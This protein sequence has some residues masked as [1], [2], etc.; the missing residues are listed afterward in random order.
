MEPKDYL[1]QNKAVWNS[2]VENH[3]QSDFYNVPSFLE[4]T[5]TLN[6][7]EM[8][9][10]ED[11]INQSILHL[12]CHFGLDTLSLARLGAKVTGV[13]FSEEAVKKARELA[14]QS[15]LPADFVCCDVYSL[16]QHLQQQF[17]V[18]FTSYGTIG[19]L[20]DLNQWAQVIEHFLKPN[21]TFVFAEFHPV[22]WMFDSNFEKIVYPY[23]NKFP[24]VEELSGSYATEKEI[25]EKHTEIC[26][27]HSL[28][29]VMSALLN[30]GLRIDAFLE[31]DYSPYNCFQGMI[32]VE[33]GKFR[34]EKMKDHL[35]LVY[36]LKATKSI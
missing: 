33:S 2:R 1:E 7:I 20:P 8:D 21:G 34:I 30:H 26:W 23:H 25:T 9:L 35:P 6:S 31:F 16:P 17:D 29:E 10:L 24:I 11:V 19:W 18:V 22:A 36:A 13:D 27:N 12:Q 14:D 4:G 32:E 15:G 5:C 28:A 3:A